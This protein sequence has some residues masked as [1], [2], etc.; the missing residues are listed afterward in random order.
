VWIHLEAQT[1]VETLLQDMRPEDQQAEYARMMEVLGGAPQ[2]ALLLDVSRT[3]H[4]AQLVA[5]LVRRFAQQWPCAL[6]DL[7]GGLYAAKAVPGWAERASRVGT[8]SGRMGAWR[9]LLP[10]LRPQI[11]PEQATVIARTHS[12]ARGWTWLEPVTVQRTWRG[13]QVQT[14]VGSRGW[15]VWVEVDG[16]DGMVRQAAFWPR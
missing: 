8:E 3:P 1:D 16:W 12:E 7:R 14:N 6:S 5:V 9:R 4:S 10:V 11:S 15:S 2:T 13:W